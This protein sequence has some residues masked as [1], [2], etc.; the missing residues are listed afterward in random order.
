M[1]RILSLLTVCLLTFV[2]LGALPAHADG[3]SNEIGACLAA[4]QVWLLVMKD[5]GAPIANEC[6]GNPASGVEALTNAGITLQFGKGEMIC[7]MDGHPE[8]CPAVFDG[9]YWS[10]YQ[11]AP[12]RSTPTPPS[13][14]PN[15]S[16]SAAPSRPGA[17]P[18]R[19]PA[20]ACP[21]S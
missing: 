16:L 18:P 2:G 6:V 1:R 11:G 12:A 3:D 20:S 21:R 10:S 14:P 4:D 19:R 13:A 8:T 15:R 9:S 7:T 17:S 5:D